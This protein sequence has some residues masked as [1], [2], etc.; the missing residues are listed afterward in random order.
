[1]IFL[2]LSTMEYPRYEGDIRIEHPEITEDQTGDTFPMVDDY[3]V[4]EQIPT[5]TYDPKTQYIAQG[6]PVQVDGT[7]QSVWVVSDYTTE[8]LAAIAAAE[9]AAAAPHT[10][11][12]KNR[13]STNVSGSAPNVI[14]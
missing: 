10:H 4:V 9:A 2:K 7:W 14:T 13:P 5:P 6:T 1:M 3:A 8:Q 12:H 11:A